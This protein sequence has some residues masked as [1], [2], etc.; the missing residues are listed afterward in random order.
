MSGENCYD[1]VWYVSVMLYIKG[2]RVKIRINV[3][4]NEPPPNGIGV[5]LGKSDN[6][7]SIYSVSLEEFEAKASS[8]TKN[9]VMCS[10]LLKIE[11]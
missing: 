1:T 11:S 10:L 3:V 6:E 7:P 4:N 9:S 8:D 2:K 5:L